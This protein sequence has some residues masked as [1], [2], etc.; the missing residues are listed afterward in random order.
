M[1]LQAVNVALLLD[2]AHGQLVALHEIG[3]RIG[4]LSLDG[5]AEGLKGILGYDTGVVKPLPVGLDAGNG[6]YSR[7]VRGGFGDVSLGIALGLAV[8]QALEDLDLLTRTAQASVS[9]AVRG[10]LQ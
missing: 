1:L 2:Q 8:G 7:L 6:R 9:G 3:G 4:S 5:G 10:R